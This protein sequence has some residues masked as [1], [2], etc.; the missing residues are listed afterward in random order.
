M[1]NM[2]V[3]V[4]CTIMLVRHPVLNFLSQKRLEREKAAFIR[5]L[6]LGSGVKGKDA[7]IVNQH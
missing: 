1:C 4:C 5:I 3:K 7:G 6:K 2:T